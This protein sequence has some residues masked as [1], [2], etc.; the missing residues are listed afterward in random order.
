M[1]LEEK[2]QLEAQLEE[3]R[4]AADQATQAAGEHPGDE[5]LQKKAEEA[6]DAFAAKEAEL[7]AVVVD[8]NPAPTGD[9]LEEEEGEGDDGEHV[10]FEEELKR[11]EGGSEGGTEPPAPTKTE[12]ER[13]ETALFHQAQRL[14]KLGGDPS[15]VLEKAGGGQEGGEPPSP[16]PVVPPVPAP[17]DNTVSRDQFVEL[18]FGKIAKSAAERKVY[19]YHYTNSI[20]RTGNIATDMENAMLIAN[21]GRIMRSFGELR[22]ANFAKP[23][24]GG[25]APGRKQPAQ[26]SVPQV[27][28]QEARV[29]RQ[30]GF[31]QQPDG[32]WKGKRYTLRYDAQKKGFAQTKNS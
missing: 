32:S 18:E 24:E 1:T 31:V 11:L 5:A 17:D 30:R 15:K 7:A 23:G 27:S 12:R 25:G 22:R 14:K 6:E 20:N 13:A 19:M 16:A 9:D 10:D 26:V 28:A 2:Q 21:K 4:K 29:L 3:L 8:D